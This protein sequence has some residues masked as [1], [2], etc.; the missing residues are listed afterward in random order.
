MPY[1]FTSDADSSGYNLRDY[2]NF[3]IGM[4]SRLPPNSDIVSL[5]VNFEPLPGLKIGTKTS[6]MRHGNSYESLTDEEVLSLF[7]EGSDVLPSDGSLYMS[8]RETESATEHTNFL[9]QEHLMY[10]IQAGV[11]ASYEHR[12]R[13]TVGFSLGTEYTFEYIRDDGV[14]ANMYPSTYTTVEE[15]KAARKLWRKALHKSFNHYFT[16]LF[17]LYY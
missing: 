1:T 10:V 6:F 15:V 11:N 14:N 5:K 16:L 8:D 9:T 7:S 4:G 13:K 17:S 2:T 12:I 3:G